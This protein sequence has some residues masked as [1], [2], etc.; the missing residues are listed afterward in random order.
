MLLLRLQ[1]LLTFFRPS[2]LVLSAG[3]DFD[4]LVSPLLTSLALEGFTM[5]HKIA[6]P[7][8]DLTEL[9]LA[10]AAPPRPTLTSESTR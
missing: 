4:S 5:N 7:C 3:D 2:V 6:R 9:A 10:F 8:M 1:S